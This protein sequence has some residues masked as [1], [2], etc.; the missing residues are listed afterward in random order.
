[1]NRSYDVC[2]WH[3]VDIEMEL[4]NVCFL[5]YSGHADRVDEDYSSRHLL[6]AAAICLL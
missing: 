1:M 3:F 5:T 4:G 6:G 2:Y